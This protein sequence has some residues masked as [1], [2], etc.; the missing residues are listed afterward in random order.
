MAKKSNATQ[1]N[2]GISDKDRKKIAEGLSRLL[3]DTYTLY[4]KTHNFHWNVTG[5]MFNTLHLMF[6]EQ[7][8]EL[9]LAVDLVA[10]RIRTLGVVAPGTYREFAKLSSIPEA[11]GVPAAEDMIRQLVEGHEAVVRTARSIFPDA[12]AASDEPTADLLTQRLQ[13]HEKTAWMLRSLL[14]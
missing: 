12:D 5:P 2:I 7:Y 10:E 6:E 14:A 1:I 4:L 3:A 11:D 8:N 13:T 9:W